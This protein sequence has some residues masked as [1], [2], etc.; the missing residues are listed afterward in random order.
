MRKDSDRMAAACGECDGPCFRVTFN[1]NTA[2]MWVVGPHLEKFACNAIHQ[3][4]QPRKAA[5]AYSA[6]MLSPLVRDTLRAAPNTKPKD[7]AALVQ[8]VLNLTVTPSLLRATTAKA[9]QQISG[10]VDTRPQPSPAPWSW[11]SLTL[12]SLARRQRWGRDADAACVSQGPQ[13]PRP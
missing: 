4:G 3:G 5:A 11:P 9:K 1:L 10:A 13:R 6:K 2:G 12:H 7:I 8:P